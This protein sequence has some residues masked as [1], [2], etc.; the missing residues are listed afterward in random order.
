MNGASG[1]WRRER[2][3]QHERALGVDGEVGDRLARGPVVRRLRRGVDDELER[4]CRTRANSRSIGVRVADVGGRR[5]CS[6]ASSLLEPLDHPRRRR[7]GAEE[8]AT[9]MS[10]STPTTSQP[11]SW[12]WRTASA[13]IRPPEP[14]T[15]ATLIAHAPHGRLFKQRARRMALPAVEPIRVGGGEA[16]RRVRRHEQRRPRPLLR[17]CAAALV[18]GVVDPRQRP[19]RGPRTRRSRRASSARVRQGGS[20]ERRGGASRR[21]ARAGGGGARRRGPPSPCTRRTR[22]AAPARRARP[23][24]PGRASAGS[25]P[26][27]RARSRRGRRSG[28]NS[29]STPS[30]STSSSG[31]SAIG[32][33]VEQHARDL[34]GVVP[35]RDV[36]A[37]R[38]ADV[39]GAREQPRSARGA[40]REVISSRSCSPPRDV[41]GQ[42]G[43]RGPPVA[44]LGQRGGEA[45][46]GRGR[47][48]HLR[49]GLGG[50]PPRPRGRS[51][52][53]AASGAPGRRRRSRACG[54]S[55]SAIRRVIRSETSAKTCSRLGRRSRPATARRRCS[56][57]RA[58]R[59]PAR[60]RRRASCPQ[61]AGARGRA[62]P[63]A[64]RP[65]PRG[66]ARPAWRPATRRSPAGRPRSRRARARAAGAGAPSTGGR[67]R[68][69][70][71]GQGRAG[72]AAAMGEHGAEASLAT[73]GTFVQI[74][75]PALPIWRC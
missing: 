44:D 62:R 43:M 39:T 67:G 27:A 66:P 3:E 65:P 36:A 6:A 5:A 55:V 30:T 42:L 9:R 7:L 12:K 71:G 38:E 26:P 2:L 25:P 24:R 4:P 18:V 37:A 52:S 50:D 53:S 72:A 45:R 63:R 74:G 8:V 16:A 33:R 51:G 19:V 48:V 59:A 34:L 10:L 28:P 68:S 61:R 40:W 54:S 46:G 69:R 22:S 15:M 32:A 58:R 17:P 1:A 11:R 35:H 47:V 56:P 60:R 21:A 57:R 64:P 13:P 31:R 75:V 70:G 14:V 23:P 20:R 29:E 41:V 49:G 73:R